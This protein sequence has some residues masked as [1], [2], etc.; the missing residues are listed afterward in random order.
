[1]TTWAQRGAYYWQDD[2]GYRVAA[3]RVGG[4]VRYGAFAS[5]L[6]YK[7]FANLCHPRYARGEAVP[8]QRAPLGCFADPES[9][10]AA[11]AR[12]ADI[13]QPAQGDTHGSAD[14]SEQWF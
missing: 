11:C 5:P 12:H 7:I 14:S 8:Q 1:M 3:F 10:R 4:A 2:A 9:A 6:D 13:T